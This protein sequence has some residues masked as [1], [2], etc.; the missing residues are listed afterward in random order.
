[1]DSWKK[2][3]FDL[4]N[5]DD[6]SFLSQYIISD[7]M[8]ENSE[9]EGDEDA[10]DFMDTQRGIQTPAST[11]SNASAT[12]SSDNI[13]MLN[14]ESDEVEDCQDV[15]LEQEPIESPQPRQSRKCSDEDEDSSLS[16]EEDI[17]WTKAF[18]FPQKFSKYKFSQPFGIT[19]NAQ[20]DLNSPVQIFMSVLTATFL[21]HIVDQSNLYSMQLN[22]QLDL[23]VA[24]FKAFLGILIIMGLHPL[25]SMGLYWS[26]DPNFYVKRVA[27]IMPLKRFLKILSFL[28]L[29]DNA[30]MPKKGQDG[31]DKLYK[32]HPLLNRIDYV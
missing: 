29:N 2:R 13:Q 16:D 30:Q 28:H 18:R 19:R 6:I 31:F 17:T 27:E 11:R 15:T 32:V 4:N 23:S 3:I 8:A 20:I 25:P 10:D 7:E 1:M 22:S 24:E 12:A 21:Q 5:P 9:A 26:T 14:L